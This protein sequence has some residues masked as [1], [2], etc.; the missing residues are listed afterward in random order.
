MAV[1][2]LNVS[3]GQAFSMTAADGPGEM[4]DA[5]FLVAEI[6]SFADGRERRQLILKFSTYAGLETEWAAGTSTT[7][8]QTSIQSALGLISRSDKLSVA[9]AGLI[10]Q[11]IQSW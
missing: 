1:I 5:D 6:D 9:Q 4:V 8:L 3:R 7:V 10:G 2:L 11:D